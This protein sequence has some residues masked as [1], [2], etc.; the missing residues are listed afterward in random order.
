MR[1]PA[2]LQRRQAWLPATTTRG[3]GRPQGPLGGWCRTAQ[4]IPRRASAARLEAVPGRAYFVFR[5]SLIIAS[6][7]SMI[8]SRE[9]RLLLKLSFRLNALV[10]GRKAKT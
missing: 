6:S 8:S 10:G 7:A 3:L 2:G 5:R 9:A 4:H 1:G